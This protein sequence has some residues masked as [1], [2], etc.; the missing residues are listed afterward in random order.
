MVENFLGAPT[1]WNPEEPH[2]NEESD[3]TFGGDSF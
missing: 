2:C 1:E 3:A